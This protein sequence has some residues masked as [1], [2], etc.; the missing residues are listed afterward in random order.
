M[1][2]ENELDAVLEQA[3]SGPDAEY[4]EEIR[5]TMQKE[6]PTY[7]KLLDVAANLFWNL[8][9]SDAGLDHLA[10]EARDFAA[11][12]KLLADPSIKAEERMALLEQTAG[13]AARIARAAI[14]LR[15]SAVAQR[16]GIAKAEVSAEQDRAIIAQYNDHTELHGLSGD[17]A[18]TSLIDKHPEI[19]TDLGISFRR[20]ADLI[21]AQRK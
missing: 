18:A 3:F 20:I 14:A 4:L 1:Q 9:Q 19:T 17:K 6:C 11:A 8:S 15:K 2:N 21:R 16:G 12:E 13:R 7:E 5:V 10:T